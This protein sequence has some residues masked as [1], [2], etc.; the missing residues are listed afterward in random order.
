MHYSQVNMLGVRICLL[1]SRKK[2]L[3]PSK[4]VGS[5]RQ[6]QI[7]RCDSPTFVSTLRYPTILKLTCWV[8]GTNLSTLKQESARAHRTGGP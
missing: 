3:M 5:N 8:C 4:L 6:G 1:W 7:W 2:I